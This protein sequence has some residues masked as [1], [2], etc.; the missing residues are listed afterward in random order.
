M[1]P[2]SV[3]QITD[4]HIHADPAT[5]MK[6]R[7][8][9]ATLAA[10]LEAVEAEVPD[11]VL[12]TGD[13]VDDASAA[14]YARLRP[15]LDRLA[16]PVHVIPGNHDSAAGIAAHLAGGNVSAAAS[17]GAG[18]W[19]IV[20]VDSTVEGEDHGHLGPDRLA[21]LDREL[22]A[23][24]EP[25]TLVVMHHPPSPI[26]SPL[27]PV[28]LRNTDELWR[29]LDRHERVRGLVWGHIHHLHESVRQGVRLLGTPSTC[30]Q[31]DGRPDAPFSHTDEPPAYRRLTLHNDGT[32][33]TEVAWLPQAVA[34][35]IHV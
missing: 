24:A 22:G 23:A 5:R 14:A 21:A 26:G 18:S 27:D 25:H 32:I 9:H 11:L 8:T 7:D 1:P 33:E 30:V 16:A 13:L 6:G 31:F 34:K 19:R 20:L 10:V 29:V 35:D 28:G 2:L 15:L 3:I 17:V 4:L 12:A